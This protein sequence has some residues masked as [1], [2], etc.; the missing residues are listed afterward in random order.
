MMYEKAQHSKYVITGAEA[1]ILQK[2]VP[3]SQRY[4]VL[5]I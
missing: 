4:L 5:G 2:W 3:Y 1:A